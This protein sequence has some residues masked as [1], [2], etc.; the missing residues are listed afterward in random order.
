MA[1]RSVVGNPWVR[2]RQVWLLEDLSIPAR[3]PRA[4]HHQWTSPVASAPA[5]AFVRAFL[6]AS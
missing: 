3:S 6:L 4:Q 2:G 1:L 5:V